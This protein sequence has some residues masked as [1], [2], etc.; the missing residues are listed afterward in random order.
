P[1]L[2]VDLGR[3]QDAGGGTDARS[4]HFER[5]VERARSKPLPPY[6]AEPLAATVVNADSGEPLEGVIVV[7]HWE[8]QSPYN[9]AAVAEVM[10]MET[11]TDTQGKF[12]FPAWGPTRPDISLTPLANAPWTG[13]LMYNAPALLLFKSDYMPL[14]LANP[15]S[16][17]PV[18]KRALR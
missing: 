13:R 4:R 1:A 10:V 14:T 9:G 15:T 6:Q 18:Y 2:G 8:V 17:F 11:M 5:F 16:G 12:A 7:A 3:E